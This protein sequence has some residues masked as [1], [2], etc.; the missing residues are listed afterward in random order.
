MRFRKLAIT[1]W[2]LKTAW[3]LGRPKAVL[4]KSKESLFV[5]KKKKKVGVGGS[6]KGVG[7]G[8][9]VVGPQGQQVAGPY[10]VR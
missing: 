3:T 9:Q 8:A 1:L 2:Q 6:G 4:E 7:K 10:T 5:D